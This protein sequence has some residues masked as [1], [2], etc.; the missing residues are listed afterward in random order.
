MDLWLVRS[1]D[2]DVQKKMMEQFGVNP[3]VRDL[4]DLRVHLPHSFLK[5]GKVPLRRIFRCG[6]VPWEL[7][8]TRSPE[9]D[10]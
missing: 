6:K 10:F 2:H 5:L 4:L 9:A 3:P 1:I 8:K 7:G